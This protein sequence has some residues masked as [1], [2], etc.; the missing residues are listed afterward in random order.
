MGTDGFMDVRDQS[1]LRLVLSRRL[2]DALLD[3]MREDGASPAEVEEA[4]G[5]LTSTASALIDALG[6]VVRG[7]GTVAVRG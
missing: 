7:D 3:G 6:I 4:A 5:L 1:E 2:R